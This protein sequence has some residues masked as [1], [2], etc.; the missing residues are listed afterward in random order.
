MRAAVLA[1]VVAAICVIPAAADAQAR[2]P[3]VSTTTS[4]SMAKAKAWWD[5]PLSRSRRPPLAV[6]HGCRVSEFYRQRHP[7]RCDWVRRWQKEYGRR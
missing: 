5:M 1:A 4:T 3:T 7:N 2:R 6:D